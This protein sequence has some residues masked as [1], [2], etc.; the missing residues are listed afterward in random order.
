MNTEEV[1]RIGQEMLDE[2]EKVIVG[3]RDV[4]ENVLLCAL[5]DGH[6]LFED[7]PGLAKTLMA[8]C[9]AQV[10]GCHF[11]RVQFTPD[12]LPADITGGYFLDRRSSQ[13]VLRKGPVFTN[14]L[15]ADE[16]NRAPPKTQS[17][18]LEAMQERQ[19]TMEG[20]THRIER[21]FLVL[22][23]QNPIEYE[24]TY[25]LP[26][27]QLDRFLMRVR[28]GYPTADQEADILRRRRR[29]GED[30]PDLE[31][32]ADPELLRRMQATVEGVHVDA[33]LDD[34]AVSLVLATRMDPNLEL[35]ASPRGSLALM[36]L[37]QARA[38]LAGRDYVLPDDIKVAA[39][40]ALSHRVM[41][42]PDPWMR[43]VRTDEVIGELVRKV[44]VPKVD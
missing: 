23:T 42:A 13:F 15:M 16:I 28:V 21:P 9:F 36:R 12:L 43:G 18:L 26:E 3:K 32:K 35:G 31:R 19:V 30:V 1:R 34:Y 41:L 6:L 17:A 10:S 40:P 5:C 2:M 39:V 20:E 22:A 29:R 27:A 11:R 7:Y 4:L 37:G 44:Q 25:P 33:A 24:G 14:V 38:T 8:T